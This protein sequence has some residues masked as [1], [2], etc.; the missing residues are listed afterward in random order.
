[1]Q[2]KQR[3]GNFIGAFAC[4]GYQKD[5]DD[6]NHLIIDLYA[7]KIVSRIFTMYEQ[8][9]GKIRIAKILNQESI[10]CPSE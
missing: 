9:V 6:H 1:M 8:G 4:Y 10:P 2:T 7:A 3:Q 5:P